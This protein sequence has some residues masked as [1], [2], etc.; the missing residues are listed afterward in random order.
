MTRTRACSASTIRAEG[1]PCAALANETKRRK[2]EE[3]RVRLRWRGM[4]TRFARKHCGPA[5]NDGTTVLHLTNR[6]KWYA[7]PKFAI[8][9]FG[10]TVAIIRSTVLGKK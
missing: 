4:P 3:G 1:C 2:R 6:Q 7:M 8:C 9:V 10:L 5:G